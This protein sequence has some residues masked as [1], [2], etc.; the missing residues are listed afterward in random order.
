MAWKAGMLREEPT[1][2]SMAMAIR[3]VGVT[4]WRKVSRDKTP[5]T[6]SMKIWV[7]ISHR[8][9]STMSAMAPAASPSTRIGRVV[10]V[11][12]SATRKVEGVSWVICHFS[13]T[14][15]IREP[16]LEAI[17]A[18]QMA[19]KIRDRKGEKA[20][21]GWEGFMGTRPLPV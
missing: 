14:L 10:P 19:R 17:A 6:V 16:M 2:M 4:R 5:A 11:S 20:L 1:P 3:I 18:I 21:G 9:R 12:M 15:W 7:A 13:P 8:R